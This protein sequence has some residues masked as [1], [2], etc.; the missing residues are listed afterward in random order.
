MASSGTIINDFTSGYRLQ[1]VWAVNSQNITN[2]TSNV[3]ATVQLV[4]LNS[5]SYINSTA[6][7]NISLT[8]NGTT[9]NSTCTV[10]ITGNQNKSLFSQ[11]VDV[12]HESDGTKTCT[13]S[14]SLGLNVNLSGTYWGTVSASGNCTFDTIAR[15][16]QPTLS[17]NTADMNTAITIYT[18]RSSTSFTHTLRYVFG[19][20]S[21]TIITDL[22]TDYNWTIP[23][24]LANQIPNS[25]SGYG[26]IYCDTYNGGSFIGTA[27]VGFTA[28]V[29]SFVVPSFST[30]TNSEANSSVS[31][32]VGQYV[33]NLSQLNLA[34][35]GAVG[36]YSST[37][38]SY[39]IIFEGITYSS[40][41]ATTG[42]VKG[43]GT[44][45]ITGNITDSRGRTASKSVN[46]NVLAYSNPQIT[47]FTI[48]RCNSDGTSNEMGTYAKI[49]STGNASSLLNGST[50]KNNLTYKISSKARAASTWTTNKTSTIVNLSLNATDILGTYDAISSF[51]FRL[52][53]T[54]KF[55]TTFSPN[56]LPTGQVA[57]SWGKNGVGIGKVW[58]QGALDVGGD[59]YSSGSY[60]GNLGSR[61]IPAS[62][63]LNS[64]ISEGLYYCP[65]NADVATLSNCPTGMAFSLFVE[66]HAG[67]K[68][69]ITEYITSSPKTFIRNLYNGTWGA[70]V[71]L[72]NASDILAKLKTVDGAGSGL[73]ADTLDSYQASD[74]AI[75]NRIGKNPA[76]TWSG[77]LL[78]NAT[79]VT[80]THSLGY[81]PIVQFD[82][83]RGNIIL[84]FGNI[85]TNQTNLCNWNSGNNSWSGTVRLY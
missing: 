14:C 36:T 69:I 25:T 73:D 60:Y 28:N 24:D 37:I 61:R 53:I 77:T 55:N 27:S 58:E 6:T 62:S 83:N 51:D 38:S 15:A 47:G 31:S 65:T 45:T 80:I 81:Y 75:Y 32:I 30:I 5:S 64:Y 42:M 2:N 21:G 33:Q 40:S 66:R 34:I 26:T 85:N 67:Y 23:L 22:S 29:P 11:N 12:P 4:S 35:S 71:E 10:G 82:G 9:Y 7:K 1:I 48:S 59:I 78:G 3:T 20:A 19:N 44:L 57:M 16:S 49:I 79:E 41:S 18:H 52:E 70:W 39:Q 17:N 63:N 56:V 84:T 72:I 46:I 50:Q 74:F 68:Q 43:S 76:F 13:I 54:D 8:I